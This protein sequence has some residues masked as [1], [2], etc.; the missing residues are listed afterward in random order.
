MLFRLIKMLIVFVF[1]VVMLI[2]I[3]PL[4]WVLSGFQVVFEKALEYLIKNGEEL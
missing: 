2:L 3:A 1:A 4:A